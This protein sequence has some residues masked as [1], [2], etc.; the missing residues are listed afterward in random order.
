MLIFAIILAW[1]ETEYYFK[2]AA[3][4]A[5]GQGPYGEVV[6]V[7]ASAWM[8]LE[9]LLLKQTARLK[10]FRCLQRGETLRIP[11]FRFDCF[12]NASEAHGLTMIDN[13]EVLTVI[14]TKCLDMI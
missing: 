7:G 3:L 5:V 4:N 1:Q 10:H 9:E 2:V 11:F 6:M 14:A 8:E 12:I 13:D